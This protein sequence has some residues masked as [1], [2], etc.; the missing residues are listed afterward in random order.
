MSDPYAKVIDTSKLFQKGKTQV[1]EEV[2]K[3]LKVADGDKLVWILGAS[4]KVFVEGSKR[5]V[6]RGYQPTG[7]GPY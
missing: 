7:R 6:T 2:R 1:P 5:K 4:D 3:M